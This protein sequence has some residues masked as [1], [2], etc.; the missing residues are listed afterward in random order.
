MECTN[1]KNLEHKDSSAVGESNKGS[2]SEVLYQATEQNP[3]ERGAGK[4]PLIGEEHLTP[5][6]FKFREP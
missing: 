6:S 4:I 1:T 3:V 2:R 5:S